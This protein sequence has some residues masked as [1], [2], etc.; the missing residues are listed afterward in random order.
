MLKNYNLLKKCVVLLAFYFSNITTFFAQ[1]NGPVCDTYTTARTRIP[2]NNGLIT[3]AH[4][5]VFVDENKIYIATLKG[6]SIST[7]GGNTYTSKQRANG[8]GSDSVNRVFASGNMVYAATHKGLSISTD[9]GLLL[10]I[11][12]LQMVW[13]LN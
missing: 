1:I 11:K 6:L 2:S 8:L 3:D 13:V 9:G 5:K 7:D 12:Q 4:R 10:P